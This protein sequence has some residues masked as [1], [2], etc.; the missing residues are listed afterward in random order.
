MDMIDAM[1]K[2]RYI[3]DFCGYDAQSRQAI[4]EMAELTQ[5]INKYWRKIL[6]CGEIKLESGTIQ[7]D[8]KE[9]QNLVEEIA[10]VQIMIWQLRY[11]ADADIKRVVKKKLDRQ[12][13]RI[14]KKSS[15]EEKDWS[16]DGKET[17]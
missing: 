7:K 3:A 9:Y 2:S 6:K 1:R 17:E 5:A 16:K 10:D 4:E 15:T 11:L 8:N 13:E 14:D 12:I